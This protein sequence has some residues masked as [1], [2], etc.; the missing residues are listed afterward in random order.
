MSNTRLGRPL[1][2][3]KFRVRIVVEKDEQDFYAYC[4]DLKGVYATGE[5]EQDALYNCASATSQHLQV[6]LEN[7]LPISINCVDEI[8]QET[9]F[10]T[11]LRALRNRQ[12]EK[13]IVYSEVRELPLAA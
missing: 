7:Q 12:S 10:E 9:W 4:P 11:I 2:E 13:R 8:V 6:M 3:V 1:Q 5:S